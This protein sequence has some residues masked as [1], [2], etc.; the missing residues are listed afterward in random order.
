MNKFYQSLWKF[1][2]VLVY[3]IVN[4]VNDCVLRKNLK[5]SFNKFWIFIK[6]FESFKENFNKI[7][8]KFNENLNFLLLSIFMSGWGVGC[9]PSIANF[10]GFG[11]K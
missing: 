8:E 2:I 9:F 1:W 4:K 7:L 10:P 11:E 6:N 3:C 5:Q